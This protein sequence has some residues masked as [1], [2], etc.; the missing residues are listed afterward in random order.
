MQGEIIWGLLTAKRSR[1]DVSRTNR[2]AHSAD[3]P[4]KVR[5]EK[6]LSLFHTVNSF[7][8]VLVSSRGCFGV[9]AIQCAHHRDTH[10]WLLLL[11]L[12]LIICPSSPR[13]EWG[14][15]SSSSKLPC[16]NRI[17][18]FCNQLFFTR[19]GDSPCAHPPLCR[20][21]FFFR[22]FLPLGFS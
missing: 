5:R 3:K 14:H 4:H 16:F 17:S 20:V 8:L 6:R 22:G 15:W 12:L 18:I 9:P 19:L 2:G 13:G 7:R 10:D 21:G 11:L 1:G